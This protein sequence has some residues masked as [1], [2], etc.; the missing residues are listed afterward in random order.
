MVLAMRRKAFLR[1][2]VQESIEIA[3]GS[4]RRADGCFSGFFY[5]PRSAG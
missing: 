4:A 5:L 1:V 2:I 3:T